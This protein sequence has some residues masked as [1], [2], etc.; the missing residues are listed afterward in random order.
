RSLRFEIILEA[1]TA[2][3]SKKEI[4]PVTYL[5]RNQLY[6]IH[7]RDTTSSNEIIRSTLSLGFHLPEHRQTAEAKWK[8]RADHVKQG[9][10]RILDIGK[11][12][13]IM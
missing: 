1:K 6:A 10:T 12:L 13:M 4:C 11:I 7:L 2:V 8:F 3:T 5:N 9:D